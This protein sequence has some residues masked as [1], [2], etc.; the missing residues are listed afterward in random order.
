MKLVIASLS[1]LAAA[2]QTPG[3]PHGGG[4]CVTPDDCSLG[5]LCT[6]SKCACDP[7]FTG[8]TCSLL[9]LQAPVDTTGGTCGPA[10]ASYHS[11]GGRTLS[12]STP[13]GD[14]KW[15]SY[16]SFMC[17]HLTLDAWTTASASAHFVSDSPAGQYAW[18]P[19][20]CDGKGIC[21]PSI[22]P[23]SH[24]TVAIT[25]ASFPAEAA[26]Q[27]WHVGDGIVPESVWY[28]CFNASQVGQQQPQAAAAAPG[29]SLSAAVGA[30]PG[31]TAY[32]TTAPS[33][34]GPWTRALNNSGVSIDFA[35]SWTQGL[36]GNPAPIVMPDG[37]VNLFF[38]ATPCPPNSGAMAP[39]CIALATSTSGYLGPY[40]ASA[41]PVTFPESEDPSVFRDPRGNYHLLTNVNTFHR[42][43]A[44]GVEW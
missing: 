11:W 8:P 22:I 33:V 5:G 27:V 3:V 12:P 14:G 15:H 41:A 20:Q 2:A 42:R 9:N 25:D 6:D 37:S 32:V 35:G 1:L 31:A 7:W 40:K 36:A 13:G 30:S 18:G 16:I 39:N 44:Q 34:S 19:E 29:W 38:T 21:T 24:N 17:K 28:P 10:F 26:V 4:N 43:C 23:W